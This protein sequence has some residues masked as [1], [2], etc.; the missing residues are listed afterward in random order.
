M[1]GPEF[2]NEPK[3]PVS[4]LTPD[5]IPDGVELKTIRATVNVLSSRSVSERLFVRWS[6]WFTLLK[7]IAWF[8]RFIHYLMH[9][10]KRHIIMPT[11]GHL[12]VKELTAAQMVVVRQVQA[13]GYGDEITR[14]KTDTQSKPTRVS[15]LRKLCP[16]LLDG[17]LCVGGRLQ[18]SSLSLSLKHPPIL[19]SNHPV[20]DLL[21][22]HYHEAEGHSGAS[23]ALGVIRR[24]FG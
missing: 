23:H 17:V 4:R 5:R 18:Y 22:R 3:I 9:K 20:T 16:I 8:R 1:Y 24:N 7:A 10:F 13:E 2:I 19:P 12:Q 15:A 14:L 11:V 6:S 21:S